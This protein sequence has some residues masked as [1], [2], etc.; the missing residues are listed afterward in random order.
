MIEPVQLRK[1]AE[2]LKGHDLPGLAKSHDVQKP[3]RERRNPLY[4]AP[5]ARDG[6]P[7]ARDGA[8][9]TPGAN[10]AD[11]SSKC[12]RP[13]IEHRQWSRVQQPLQ[14]CAAHEDFHEA[15]LRLER[16]SPF[17][18]ASSPARLWGAAGSLLRTF[19]RLQPRLP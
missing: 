11:E 6:A 4:G 2:L 1:R 9:P 7:R 12:R 10:Q 19:S 18:R 13:R 16:H 5:R 14:W 8:L 15:E 17:G 3:P